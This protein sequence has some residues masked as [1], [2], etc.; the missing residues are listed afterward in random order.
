MRMI[1][2]SDFHKLKTDGQGEYKALFLSDGVTAGLDSGYYWSVRYHVS[3]LD[4]LLN[5]NIDYFELMVDIIC[6]KEL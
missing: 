3:I 1:S 2:F 5:T 6:P 4:D